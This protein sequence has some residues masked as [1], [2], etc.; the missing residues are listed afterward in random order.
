MQIE[1]IENYIRVVNVRGDDDFRAKPEEKIISGDRD[2]ILGNQH[3]M[4]KKTMKERE[5]VIEEYKKDL[6]KDLSQK[7]PIWKTL[8]AIS[9]D[10]VE[11]E[12]KIAL[13]CFCKPLGCHLDSLIPVII[14]M[15]IEK[16]SQKKSLKIKP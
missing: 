3:I 1:D 2:T 12:Q 4:V 11:N 16:L 14:D 5:R 15:A 6:K 13:S 7:G 9:S 10:I 8:Q